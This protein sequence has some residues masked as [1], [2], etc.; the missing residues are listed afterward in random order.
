MENKHTFISIVAQFQIVADIDANLQKMLGVM[1]DAPVDSVVV[2]PE[3]VLSGY[4]PTREFLE[5]IDLAA[6]AAAMQVLQDTAIARKLHL[7]FGSLLLEGD[8]W[9]N[10]GI[11][12]AYNAPQFVYRKV[13]LATRERGIC[14][15][16]D[17]L[18]LVDMKFESFTARAGIQLCREIRFPEQWQY[19]ARAGAEFFVYMTNAIGAGYALPVWRS[20]LVSRAAENQRWLLAANN[21]AVE[22]QVHTMVIDPRGVVSAE[23]SPLTSTSLADAVSTLHTTIDLSRNSNWYLD[24]ARQD[25]VAVLK[26]GDNP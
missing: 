18:P 4:E 16:G 21:A 1:A 6:L 19:L 2:F 14:K 13:N 24:Q 7:F 25:V 20:H 9:V 11:Y 3:G 8:E 10:A 23:T 17:C 5:Q 12:M 22:Q 26:T 15:A